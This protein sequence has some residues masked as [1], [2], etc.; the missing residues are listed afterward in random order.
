MRC[1]FMLWHQF[2]PLSCNL[3]SESGPGLGQEPI[4]PIDFLGNQ[5]VRVT[6]Q[7]VP[8][9]SPAPLRHAAGARPHDAGA[10]APARHQAVSRAVHVLGRPRLHG[11]RVG[12][13]RPLILRLQARRQVR[14]SQSS[15]PV[16]TLC[17]P[18]LAGFAATPPPPPF[19]KPATS[20]DRRL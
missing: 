19:H 5:P 17:Y 13:C 8:K 1:L 14:P 10:E 4:E 3:G 6:K 7:R 11:A 15:V 2:K 9:R 16:T 12:R 18:K 20:S